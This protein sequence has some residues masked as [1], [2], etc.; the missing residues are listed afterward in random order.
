MIAIRPDQ[1]EL[2]RRE[3]Q[4]RQE[5]KL[6]RH[7]TQYYS[8]ECREA[9]GEPAVLKVVRLGIDNAQNHGYATLKQAGFYVGLMFMLGVDFDVDP[10]IP[11]AAQKLDDVGVADRDQRILRVHEEA[12]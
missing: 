4:A 5:L 6:V 7:F 9:G 3:A 11:W 8:R 1:I 2:F 10:Q 12:V